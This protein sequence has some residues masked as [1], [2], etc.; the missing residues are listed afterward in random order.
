MLVNTEYLLP[1]PPKTSIHT[2]PLWHVFLVQGRESSE[3]IA[4]LLIESSGCLEI[5]GQSNRCIRWLVVK[6]RKNVPPTLIH[7]FP[8]IPIPVVIIQG[9]LAMP[10]VHLLHVGANLVRLWPKL[11]SRFTVK[12]AYTI[13]IRG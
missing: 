11:F 3:M 12:M 9:V 4:F 13:H 8:P 1:F 7:S 5:S 2:F 6:T 10:V